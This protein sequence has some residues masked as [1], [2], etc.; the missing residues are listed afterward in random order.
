MAIGITDAGAVVKLL[1]KRLGGLAEVV[2]QTCKFGQQ[3]NNLPSMPIVL[4]LATQQVTRGGIGGH[5]AL[6]I[7]AARGTDDPDQLAVIAAT[8]LVAGNSRVSSSC[9][10]QQTAQGSQAFQRDWGLRCLVAT[11]SGIG[12]GCVGFGERPSGALRDQQDVHAA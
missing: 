4:V 1:L 6:G 10:F 3:A 12:G 9:L 2:E 8:N 5:A 7:E 11:R